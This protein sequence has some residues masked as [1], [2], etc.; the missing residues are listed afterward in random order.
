MEIYPHFLFKIELKE[1][2]QDLFG[3]WKPSEQEYVLLSKCRF[4]TSGN[5]RQN[6]T[7]SNDTSTY[8]NGGIIY[9]PKNCPKIKQGDEILVLD[10]NFINPNGKVAK[11]EFLI[12]S[13]VL[14]FEQNRL[15]TRIWL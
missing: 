1:S 10:N 11:N 5:G 6:Q 2:E 12:K 14:Q 15:H 4:E 8:K 9:A 3:N 13:N 7:N